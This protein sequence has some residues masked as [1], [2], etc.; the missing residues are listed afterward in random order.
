MAHV[1]VHI[2]SRARRRLVTHRGSALS[3]GFS[4][5]PEPASLA[6]THTYVVRKARLETGVKTKLSLLARTQDGLVESHT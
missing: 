2:G 6:P 3:S 4:D 5:Y 1:R